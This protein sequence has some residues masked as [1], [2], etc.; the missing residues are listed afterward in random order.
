M[1]SRTKQGVLIPR[2]SPNL[3]FLAYP[4]FDQQRELVFG[5]RGELRNGSD[6]LG[7]GPLGSAYR[8]T[9]DTHILRYPG[10][11]SSDRRINRMFEGTSSS[12]FM[13]GLTISSFASTATGQSAVFA[14]C[15]GNAPLIGI[16]TGTPGAGNL[17][18]SYYDSGNVQRDSGAFTGLLTLNSPQVITLVRTGPNVFAY[19]NGSYIGATTILDGTVNTITTTSTTG[20]V[21]SGRGYSASVDTRS[22]IG[23]FWFLAAWNTALSHQQISSISANPLILTTSVS[24]KVAYIKNKSRMFLTL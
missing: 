7:G 9:A 11:Q 18:F 5:Y 1:F 23:R 22:Y 20:W 13:I 21:V 10:N 15:N 4:G 24:S 14:V 19:R 16:G 6:W 2:V 12:T 3:A 17:R 8:T